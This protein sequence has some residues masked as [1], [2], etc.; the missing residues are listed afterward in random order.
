MSDSKNVHDEV[1]G[2]LND[3]PPASDDDDFDLLLDNF[4]AKQMEDAQDN[5]NDAEELRQQNLEEVISEDDDEY[6]ANL[7]TEEKQLFCPF[8]L[9][10]QAD[11]YLRFEIH[12]GI[13]FP[14]K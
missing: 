3:N 9:H 6:A 7:A 1:A 12:I 10:V 11:Q 2:F 5:I 4:I 8:F 14:Q 13:R